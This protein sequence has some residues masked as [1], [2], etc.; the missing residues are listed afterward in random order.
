MLIYR[1]RTSALD[2]SGKSPRTFS[3]NVSRLFHGRGPARMSGARDGSNGAVRNAWPNKNSAEILLIQESQ[4]ATGGCD[5]EA[6]SRGR[7]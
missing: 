7:D 5:P 4:S 3:V 1:W 2:A 6:E